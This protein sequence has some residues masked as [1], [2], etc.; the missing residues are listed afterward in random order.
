MTVASA[1]AVDC[2][3]AGH[4]RPLRH[5][6]EGERA[7]LTRQPGDGDQHPVLL[8]GGAKPGPG[9]P[10]LHAPPR[11]DDLGV[12]VQQR[13]DLH[14]QGRID[15]GLRVGGDDRRLPRRGQPEREGDPAAESGQ[16]APE[17][18]GQALV[19]RGA[20]LAYRL[21]DCEL[22]QVER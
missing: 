2:H 18:L 10:A 13:G 21:A 15:R 7:G 9:H 22:E 14:H 17:Q 12:A 4:S 5:Q 1:R 16:A 19:G 6:D 11:G 8:P 3:S 20:F